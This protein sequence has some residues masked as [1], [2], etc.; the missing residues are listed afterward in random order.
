MPFPH[1][2]REMAGER[3]PR[4]KLTET[5]VQGIRAS[6]EPQKIIA[7]R[8]GISVPQVSLIRNGRVWRHLH[9]PRDGEGQGN[10]TP[11]PM[12]S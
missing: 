12:G 8:Y 2:A 4:A 11:S 7:Y 10:R 3:N 1:M 5:Q 6:R 9:Q